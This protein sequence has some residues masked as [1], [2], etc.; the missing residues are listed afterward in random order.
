MAGTLPLVDLS[1][2][3]RRWWTK[4]GGLQDKIN[5]IIAFCNQLSADIDTLVAGVITNELV[6]SVNIQTE[7]DNAVLDSIAQVQQLAMT[8]SGKSFTLPDMTA[9]GYDGLQITIKNAGAEAFGL[10]DNSGAYLI[11]SLAPGQEAII[12]LVDT[13][14]AAGNWQAAALPPSVI[15]TGAA[16]NDFL[17]YDGTNLVNKTATQVVAALDLTDAVKSDVTKNL[18]AGYSATVYDNGTKSTGT[19]TPDEANGNIQKVVN[20][21]AHTLAP[22]ANDTTLIIQYTNNASAG[23]ITTSGF[24]RVDG[25][26]TTTNGDDFLCYITKAGTFTHLNIVE[27]Q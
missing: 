16:A 6:F 3:L 22:P 13:L 4:E 15:L 8:T 14:T 26:F 19:F 17:Q 1:R 18:T 7:A 9:N 23:A 10:K 24:T 12:A 2:G 27:L 20:G 11:T 25:A 21:G 5:G